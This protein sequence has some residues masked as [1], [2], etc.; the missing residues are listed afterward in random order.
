M[1]IA[2][3]ETLFHLIGWSILHAIW[4]ATAIGFALAAVLKL[5]YWAKPQVRYAFACVALSGMLLL[6]SVTAVVFHSA[7]ITSV[8]ST[9]DDTDPGEKPYS[10]LRVQRDNRTEGFSGSQTTDSRNMPVKSGNAFSIVGDKVLPFLTLIW[11]LG[12]VFYAS[13]L[14]QG[15]YSITR[16]RR[17]KS[18]I[19]APML[20]DLLNDLTRRLGLE[21]KIEIYVSPLI[22]TPMTMGW[23][24]PL[25]LIP[26]SSLLGLS[27]H[28]L[29]TIIAHELI[30]IKRY[31]YVINVLQSV[32][33][34]LLFF[35]PAA[36]WASRKIREEREFVCDDLTV[37][38]CADPVDYA[39]ALTRL[40]RFQQQEEKLALA[41]TDGQLR[42]RI[43]R[44]VSHPQDRAVTTNFILSGFYS[45]IVVLVALAAALA[46]FKVLSHNEAYG[47]RDELVEQ[48]SKTDTQ[49]VGDDGRSAENADDLSRENPRFREAAL[50][51]LGSHR[52]SVIV[53]DPSTGR[54][55]SVVNQDWAF[56]RQWAPGS[57]FKLVT[58]LAAIE[59]NKL[60]ESNKGF[61][62]NA[63]IQMDLARSLAASDND[64]FD[65][66]GREIGSETLLRYSK[67]V[68][69]G[70]KTG[71]NHA[72]EIGAYVPA[73][74]DLENNDQ[75]GVAGG[76]IQVTPMQLAV[77]VS[78]LFN[79]GRIL[80]PQSISGE[81]PI[82]VK[83][84]RSL[85]IN[86]SSITELRKGL[87][88]TIK[89]G[90]GKKAQQDSY[91]V[92]GKTG[93]ISNNDTD[94]GL[95]AS[96][97]SNK[98]SEL[99]IVVVLEG[100]GERGATAAQIAGKIYASV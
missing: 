6:P 19:S 55:Y 97:G 89:T 92:S 79:G 77:L 20:T 43:N 82:T 100:K 14:G 72:G 13:R 56:R 52:G 34:T 44:I 73:A 38:L 85:L 17:N 83:D 60:R 39:R 7:Q 67:Q 2:E 71:I 40:A 26:P 35:H 91:Q 54:V 90:T 1:Q 86:E 46:G 24:Y 48:T 95:F 11:L 99:V 9:M 45:L 16:L 94:I 4:Q 98:N 76:P 3:I 68:G 80:V 18:R 10:E 70:E 28:Q 74:E 12:V 59:E 21:R 27:P 22:N 49:V 51:A 88:A 29:Q 65:V 47:L 8:V 63:A 41:S 69:F 66:I 33:E 37:A 78:A 42:G 31:D 81:E 58:A 25:V 75:M 61:G 62:Y 50:R 93:T 87:R 5:L 30:H 64:Y 32:V 57:T 15:M 96:Y 53:M 84:R 36:S 23:I